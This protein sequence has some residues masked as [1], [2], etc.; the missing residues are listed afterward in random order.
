M[1]ETG[2]IVKEVRVE[3]ANLTDLAQS[4]THGQR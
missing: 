4:Y 3:N 2:T 1:D